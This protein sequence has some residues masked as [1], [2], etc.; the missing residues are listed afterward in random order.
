MNFTV[1]LTVSFSALF[2]VSASS[3]YQ[4]L[5]LLFVC[6]SCALEFK[7]QLLS[8]S[9]CL[10]AVKRLLCCSGFKVNLKHEC[11]IQIPS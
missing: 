10:F 1:A 4:N 5:H 11:L 9:T 7:I 3:L 6:L 2:F 8:G